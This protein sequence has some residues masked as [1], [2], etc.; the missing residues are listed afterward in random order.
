MLGVGGNAG[1]M[2]VISLGEERPG[3]MRTSPIGSRYIY[4]LS[5]HI[6]RKERQKKNRVY[7]IITQNGGLGGGEKE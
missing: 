3:L 6:K 1:Q 7:I 5:K 2:F 4:A